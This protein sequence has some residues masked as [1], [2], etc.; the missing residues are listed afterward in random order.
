MPSL[1]FTHISHG[2]WHEFPEMLYVQSK[3]FGVQH[4]EGELRNTSL[5][6]EDKFWVNQELDGAYFQD[7]R[8]AK[9]LRAL[10]GLMSNGLRQTIP[11]AYLLY[12][13]IFWLWRQERKNQRLPGKSFGPAGRRLYNDGPN[14][15]IFQ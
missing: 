5:S 11:L 9:R 1:S 13:S 6:W 7:V 4:L 8:P 2:R 3:R 14:G 10:P 15:Q 12:A